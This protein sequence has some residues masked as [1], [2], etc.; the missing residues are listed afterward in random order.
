ME[1][2]TGEN[3]RQRYFP[4]PSPDDFGPL[5]LDNDYAIGS[6][7]HRQ[8][9]KHVEKFFIGVLAHLHKTLKRVYCDWKFDN[10]LCF[11]DVNDANNSNHDGNKSK[12][13]TAAA[14]AAV[15]QFPRLKLTDF[16]SV[17]Q[18]KIDIINPKNCNQLFTP[19][20]LCGA[21]TSICPVFEDDYKSV[22]YLMYKLNGK[23]LPW[24]N[25]SVPTIINEFHYLTCALLKNSAEFPLSLDSLVYW[26]T[27]YPFTFLN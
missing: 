26:P 23:T 7:E 9:L 18:N 22:C 25:L 17:Q 2:A 12:A 6:I 15:S 19:L 27:S 5:K 8:F 13:V 4:S 20:T 21:L 10:I 11:E 16:S 24:E 3:M 14:A 1:Y